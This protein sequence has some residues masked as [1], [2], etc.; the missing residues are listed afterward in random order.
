MV[1]IPQ[2]DGS[3]IR[4]RADAVDV[5]QR[6]DPRERKY[7]ND[8]S[9]REWFTNLTQGGQAVMDLRREAEVQR[10]RQAEKDLVKRLVA[11]DMS[12]F[13]NEELT[14]ELEILKDNPMM[15]PVIRKMEQEKAKRKDKAYRDYIR[16][17]KAPGKTRATL[18]QTIKKIGDDVSEP[19][20]APEPPP[21]PAPVAR[22]AQFEGEPLPELSQFKIDENDL[23]A[24]FS[25]EG[26][27]RRHGRG[28]CRFNEPS[29]FC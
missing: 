26:F 23:S 1:D 18:Q 14:S 19:V 9:L 5:A 21:V 22:R 20:P 15:L 29:Y 28:F 16:V 6:P 25:G 27:R 13:S 8:L 17:L 11:Q 10:V 4:V 12:G 7:V 3:T 2:A 24:F